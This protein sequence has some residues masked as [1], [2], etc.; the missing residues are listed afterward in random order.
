MLQTIGNYMPAAFCAFLSLIALVGIGFDG[1][2]WRPAFFS[3]L[4]LCFVF[5]GSASVQMQREIGELRRQLAE[6]AGN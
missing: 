2:W 5:V 6:M 3:F 1:E 4:P